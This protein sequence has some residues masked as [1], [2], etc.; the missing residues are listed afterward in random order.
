MR[1]NVQTK[2]I[3]NRNDSRKNSRK[4]SQN[5]SGY[6]RIRVD[7]YLPCNRE[8]K[9]SLLCQR[10]CLPSQEG[11]RPETDRTEPCRSRCIAVAE[12][13]TATPRF[14]VPPRSTCTIATPAASHERGKEY[15]DT[16]DRMQ[17]AHVHTFHKTR[18]RRVKT[19]HRRSSRDFG[20]FTRTNQARMNRTK[21][22]PNKLHKK[23]GGTVANIVT[24]SASHSQRE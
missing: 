9:Q 19:L 13:N 21:Q 7:V 2:H 4:N 24:A 10:T 3:V 1:S 14:T 17:T 11:V 15:S 5:R 18:Q 22:K 8:T 16:A 23:G 20:C 6:H 12:C